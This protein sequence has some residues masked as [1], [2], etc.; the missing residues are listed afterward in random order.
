MGEG[1]SFSLGLSRLFLGG[2]GAVGTHRKVACLHGDVSIADGESW[3]VAPV[4][5]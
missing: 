5:P 4:P 2:V 3:K 1:V